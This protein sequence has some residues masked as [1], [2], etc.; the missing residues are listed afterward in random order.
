[1]YIHTSL[2]LYVAICVCGKLDAI[3]T[4]VFDSKHCGFISLG[5][6]W[7]LIAARG[8]SLV[9]SRPL[10]SLKCVG[11]SLCWLLLSWSSVSAHGLSCLVAGGILPD[12]G[13]ILCP[14]RWQVDS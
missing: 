9:E 10:S 4:C 2:F 8:L 1:M 11:F 12:Q 3:H 5:L 14:L 6:Q 13:S 7:R